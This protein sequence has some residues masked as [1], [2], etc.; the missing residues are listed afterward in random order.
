METNGSGFRSPEEA[1]AAAQFQVK[2]NAETAAIEANSVQ[3]EAGRESI[4]APE[5]ESTPLERNEAQYLAEHKV[6]AESSKRSAEAEHKYPLEARY[7]DEQTSAPYVSAEIAKFATDSGYQSE[8]TAEMESAVFTPETSAQ[9]LGQA[10]R[11]IDVLISN[12][13][14]HQAV[15]KEVTA[16]LDLVQKAQEQQ[17]LPAT[18][19][20]AD[21][22]KMVESN[23][24]T[25]AFEDRV[26]SENLL[27]DHGIR[28][29]VSH[30]IEVTTVL[31]D[32]LERNGQEVRAVDR[33]IA[34]QTMIDHDLGYAMTPVRELINREGLKG[35]DA[36]HN[37]LAAKFVRERGQDQT[38]PMSRLFSAD[39]LAV[40]HE[41]ILHH[42]SS[43][44]HFDL[45]DQSDG[46][47]R[48]NIYSAV[49]LADNSDAFEDKLPELIYSVPESLKSMR[50]LK[51]AG[52]IGDDSMISEIKELLKRQVEAQA[53][54]SKDD[55]DAIIRAVDVLTADN[56]KFSVGRI[57]GNNPELSINESGVVE[58]KVQESAIHQEVIG[59][60]GQAEYDQ[61][62]KFVADL[63]G[64]EKDQVNLDQDEI[65]T[66]NLVIKIAKGEVQK[67]HELTD[68]QSRIE[69]LIREPEFS[70][71]AST[72]RD[73]SARQKTIEATLNEVAKLLETE[74]NAPEAGVDTSLETAQLLQSKLIA[75]KEERR[76]LIKEY[77]D[78]T[79]GGV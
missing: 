51:T 44:V 50:L 15:L 71:F 13:E 42:D 17:D 59:L 56:Y 52:E 12:P 5:K 41:G 26:A 63:T 67:S 30:N 27:G 31:F 79:S 33:L 78:K 7:N 54:W 9:I 36:G 32:E 11:Q 18:I 29:I 62:R 65:N 3:S 53:G 61:L 70:F 46:A 75:I 37:L 48:E 2:T 38:D 64:I 14:K 6:K 24:S 60:Y 55:K 40:I 74:V 45:Q 49:H 39:Q 8:I 4:D 68:Y 16:Y 1:A 72:D 58:I 66:P 76:R 69:T 77:N 28:H 23:I 25:L 22:A 73:L 19:S 43:S 35:Q 20:M 47:R 10:E 21:I 57:C 34:H